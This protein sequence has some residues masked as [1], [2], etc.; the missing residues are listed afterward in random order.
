MN[1]PKLLTTANRYNRHPSLYIHLSNR[2]S[3]H[4]QSVHYL[5][6]HYLSVHHPSGHCR[7]SI[8]HLS[9]IHLSIIHLFIHP[10]LYHLSVCPSIIHLSIIHLSIIY[11]SNQPSSTASCRFTEGP[12]SRQPT[13]NHTWG[14]CRVSGSSHMQ[15]CGL[16]TEP[17]R[18]H[19]H[20]QKMKLYT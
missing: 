15:V 18:T 13:H 17:E 12:T 10:S 19:K 16:W 4:H 3:V 14:Q 1:D 11:V 9:V 8:I 20:T 6:I 5:S 7:L 2:P